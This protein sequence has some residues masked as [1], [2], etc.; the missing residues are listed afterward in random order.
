MWLHPVITSTISPITIYKCIDLL[1]LKI[2]MQ[3]RILDESGHTDLSIALNLS[4]K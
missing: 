4:S 2:L 3:N 1:S